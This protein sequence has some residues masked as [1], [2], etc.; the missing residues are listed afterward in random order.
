M[1]A[2]VPGLPLLLFAAL[3]VATPVRAD[4][5]YRVIANAANPVTSVERRFLADVF[6][7]KTTR[8][9]SGGAARP[10]DQTAESP[11]RRRFCEEA[12][13]RP[14]DAVRNYWQQQVFSGR[15][16][17][18]PELDGDEEVLRYVQKYPGAIGY[19]SAAADVRGVRVLGVR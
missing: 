18:P 5:A 13:G 16:V 4:P 11:I 19:V 10:V 17:P 14:L 12:I 2:R 9:P 6:L 3:A 7:K 15:D 1:R 8:W